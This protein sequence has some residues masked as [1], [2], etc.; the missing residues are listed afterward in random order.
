[1]RVPATRPAAGKRETVKITVLVAE[2]TTLVRRLLVQQLAREA[3]IQVVG[4]AQDGRE[5]VDQALRTRP[6]VVLMD[7]EMPA[8]NGV[9]ATQRILA[10]SPATRI[11]VLT[12]HEDL[13]SVGRLAGAAECLNK[14]VTPSELVAAIRRVHAAA[15]SATAAAA[16][17]AVAGSA[18][19]GGGDTSAGDAAAASA[20]LLARRAAALAARGGL[21]DREGAVLEKIVATEMTQ[22]QIARTLSQEWGQGFTESAVKHALERLMT[23]LRVEPRT[24]AALVKMALDTP[25]PPAPPASGPDA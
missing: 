25:L 4:E 8:L 16:A 7:L 19:E 2:D 12:S 3:D 23:K 18:P 14:G 11:V 17:A 10:S 24:R 1:M 15:A 22:G 20:G 13:T 5:A 6:D 21:T 9:Q